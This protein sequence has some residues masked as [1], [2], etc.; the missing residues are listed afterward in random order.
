MRKRR[1]PD[2]GKRLIAF[3]VDKR[4]RPIAYRDDRK[5]ERWI[6]ISYD[7]AKMQVSTGKATQVPYRKS[8]R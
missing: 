3:T 2:K 7:E 4:G 8:G 5:A 1:N 6:R